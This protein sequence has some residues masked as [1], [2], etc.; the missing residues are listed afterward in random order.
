M[1]ED[2]KKLMAKMNDN[3]KA[4]EVVETP[5]VEQIS[6]VANPPKVEVPKPI[7][8][9]APADIPDDIDEEDVEEQPVAEEIEQIPVKQDEQ[10]SIE[11]EVAVLQNVGIY[12]R[13]KILVE[14]EKVDVLKVIAQTLLDIKK[15]LL[16]EENDTPKK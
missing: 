15:K 16:G 2:L 10:N 11:Q 13:E 14:R 4:P 5:T 12:R 1:S 6:K 7:E 8:Q 9:P 3:K